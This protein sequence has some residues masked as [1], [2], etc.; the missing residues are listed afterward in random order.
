MI[1]FKKGRFTA[2]LLLVNV[3]IFRYTQFLAIMKI[4]ITPTYS[5]IFDGEVP[6]LEDLIKDIPSETV[7]SILSVISSYLYLEG[8]GLKTQFRVLNFLNLRQSLETRQSILQRLFR[9]ADKEESIEFFTQL[10][11]MEFLHY[12]F[13]HYRDFKINDT[14]PYQELNFLKAYFVIAEQVNK[15]YTTAFDTNKELAGDYF[16][17]SIWPTLFDQFEVNHRSNPF[18]G[19]IK[20]IAFLNFMEFYSPYNKYVHEFLAKH[21]KKKSWNYILDLMMLIKSSWDE[22]LKK[23]DRPP[24]SFKDIE[25]FTSLFKSFAISVEEYSKEYSLGKKNFSGFK[26]KPL[27]EILNGHYIVINWDF[28]SNKLY[29]GLLF[30]FYNQSGISENENFKDFITFK[31]YVSEK[32]TEQFLFQKLITQCFQKKHTVTVF[33]HKIVDGFPDAYVRDGKTIFLFEIK[34]AAF[35]VSSSNSFSFDTIKTT[36]DQ[37]YN[38]ERK[39]TAQLIKHLKLLRDGTFESKTFEQLKLKRRNLRVYPIMVYTDK[40]FNAPGI[41][42]YLNAEFKKKISAAELE[43]VF[44]KIENLTFLNLSFLIDNIQ[45]FTDEKL[46]FRNLIDTYNQEIVNLEKKNKKKN[47]EIS[48]LLINESFEEVMSRKHSSKLNKKDYIKT[49]VEILNLTEN[50]D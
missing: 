13:T 33:D 19:M 35:P 44:G 28:L 6:K 18:T 38:S 1:Y 9:R 36:I 31:K 25:G 34:D 26:S 10:Y 41:N 40:F 29:D 24:F 4:T 42:R 39:G 8:N 37:K 47:T 17:K 12:E 22:I 7:I 27:F 2:L 14:T 49:I 21:K 5:D 16:Q 46:G 11:C 30:D 3:N 15:K 43:N 32:L 50:L 45:L 23:P 48:L 20:G